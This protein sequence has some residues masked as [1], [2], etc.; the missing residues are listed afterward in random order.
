MEILLVVFYIALFVAIIFFGPLQEF[1]HRK[2]SERDLKKTSHERKADEPP[3][4]ADPEKTMT[5]LPL[6][7]TILA[8][9]FFIWKILTTAFTPL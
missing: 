1:L 4:P 7:L 5:M 9:A 2:K 3:L 8:I 6:L